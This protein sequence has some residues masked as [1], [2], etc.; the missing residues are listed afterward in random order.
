ME[1]EKTKNTTYFPGLVEEEDDQEE[2]E[3]SEEE[4][5]DDSSTGS[6]KS[7]EWT[8]TSVEPQGLKSSR[9]VSK[10]KI[11]GEKSVTHELS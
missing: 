6:A 4:E 11:I 2:R 1:E 10:V 9:C 7:E 8:A 5:S 3:F